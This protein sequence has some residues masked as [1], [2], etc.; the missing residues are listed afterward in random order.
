[1]SSDR[2]RGARSRS[3]ALNARP[4]GAR[5]PRRVSEC[6]RLAGLLGVGRDTATKALARASSQ[7]TRRERRTPRCRWPVRTVHGLVI[8]LAGRRGR[9]APVAAAVRA[10]R[11]HAP[12][13][14]LFDPPT[15]QRQHQPAKTPTPP[16]TRTDPQ[17]NTTDPNHHPPTTP[18]PPRQS[19][20]PN[21]RKIR[22]HL[23]FECRRTRRGRCAVLSIG[24]W[25]TARR[26]T[27]CAR[28]AKGVEDYYVGRGEAPGRW[29]GTMT[30]ELGLDGR[31]SA[32][33]LRQVLAGLDPVSGDRFARGRERRV[34]GFDL[35]FCAPKSVSVL[36]GLGDS[37][38]QRRGARRARRPRS[39][40]RFGTSRTRRAGRDGAR[41]GSSGPRRRVRRAPRSGIARAEPATRTCTPTSSSRTR[42]AATTA[43]GSARRPPPLPARQDRRLPLRGAAPRRAH[44]AGSA[45]TWTPVVNGIADIVGIPQRG[46]RRFSTR[47]ARDRGRDG[48]ARGRARRGPRSTRCSRPARPRTTT[49]TPSLLHALVDRTSRRARLAPPT[50]STPCSASRPARLHRRGRRS[51]RRPAPRSRRAHQA[52]QH[53]RSPRRAARLVR[54]THRRRRHHRHRTARR[55][56]PRRSRGRAAR[57]RRTTDPIGPMRRRTNRT[58][59]RH[60]DDRHRA[61]R[62]RT[63]LD[64]RSTPRATAP[65]PTPTSRSASPTRT[66][67][68][69]RCAAR[70]EPL[71]ANKSRWSRR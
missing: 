65:S 47:R 53:V 20:T 62:P 34:P 21:S 9:G 66:P 64:A 44:R 70:P 2:R 22:T 32:D 67:C 16:T 51:D 27:T 58:A 30:G 56:D 31:V 46:A 3:L 14:T 41:T 7:R 12:E 60:T 5:A 23:H 25:A 29:L 40:R 69:P 63:L 54:A 45:S 35:T 13:P 19:P 68:S 71:S 55:P 17:P 49:S 61:T 59:D 42:P 52:G 15:Q 4:E 48:R 26:T 43:V 39:T 38:T 50:N 1:M 18:R 28:S 33:D 57:S 11:V 8:A 24:A 37:E 36:W 6:P 10:R